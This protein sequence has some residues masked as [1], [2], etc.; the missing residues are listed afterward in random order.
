MESGY[1][2]KPPGVISKPDTLGLIKCSIS[3]NYYC[4]P[5]LRG[6]CVISFNSEDRLYTLS[7]SRL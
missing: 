7:Q 4:L 1:S 3:S 5:W 6:C 2:L